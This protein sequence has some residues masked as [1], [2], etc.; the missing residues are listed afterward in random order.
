R[1]STPSTRA[2]SVPPTAPKPPAFETPRAARS[3]AA[4]SRGRACNGPPQTAPRSMSDEA[5]TARTN[6]LRTRNK[7][8]AASLLEAPLGTE[9]LHA[10]RF[11]IAR[12]EPA[13]R[14]AQKRS[15]NARAA[16]HATK[17]APPHPIEQR[18]ERDLRL[19]LDLDD[20]TAFA[21][22]HAS[23]PQVHIPQRTPRTIQLPE[24]V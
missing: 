14:H 22:D 7:H 16:V 23:H 11:I 2:C 12:F 21:P 8:G 5:N 6:A 20:G 1:A 24:P 9:A 15:R 17:D 3:S 19:A 13:N 10:R 4:P 18:Y